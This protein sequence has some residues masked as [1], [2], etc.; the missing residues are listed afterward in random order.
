VPDVEVPRLERMV[1][2]FCMGFALSEIHGRF[3]ARQISTWS[4]RGKIAPGTAP[5]H[6]RLGKYL[7]LPPDVDGEYEL[8]LDDLIAVV[9]R[10]AA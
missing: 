8:D 3:D 7:D 6:D 9:A 4:E 1:T 2:T 10:R 5:L